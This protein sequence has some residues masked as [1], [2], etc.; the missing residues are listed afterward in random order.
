MQQNANAICRLHLCVHSSGAPTEH[1]PDPALAVT[2]HLRTRRRP[3]ALWPVRSRRSVSGCALPSGQYLRAI[4]GFW[5]QL[6]LSVQCVEKEKTRR[7]YS[8][9]VARLQQR[10]ASALNG[11]RRVAARAAQRTHVTAQNRALHASGRVAQLRAHSAM[12]AGFSDFAHRKWLSSK[13]R[14]TACDV[15]TAELSRFFQQKQQCCV[16][17]PSA[18]PPSG[19]ELDAD[20]CPNAQ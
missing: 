5:L 1:I 9:R 4:G 11:V 16:A 12:G 13:A 18:P 19:F 3:A 7:R 6:Q 8:I 14:R 10:V 2:S 20:C 15:K 17:A